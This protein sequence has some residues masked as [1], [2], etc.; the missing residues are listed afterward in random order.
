[1]STEAPQPTTTPTAPPSNAPSPSAAAPTGTP[2]AAIPS[3]PF[4][5]G[6]NA[7]TWA[8]GKTAEEVLGIAEKLTGVVQTYVQTNAPLPTQPAPTYNVPTPTAP[9]FDP[10]SYIQRRDMETLAPRMIQD[11]VAPQFKSLYENLA[12]SNLETVKRSNAVIFEKY[13][14]EV[15]S[16][17]AKVPIEQ[18]TV[19]N[20]TTIVKLVR[21][22]HVDE[23]ASEIASRRVAEMEPTLRSN[24]SPAVP[25][26]TQE[27]KYTLQSDAIPQDWKDRAATAGLTEQAVEEFCRANDMTKAQFYSQF[28][29][30]AITEVTQRG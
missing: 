21:A 9:T 24:G 27:Q 19:D 16:Y 28:G 4:R 25:V 23:L 15:Y 14:P 5:Y 12:Q 2:S 13:G 29:K 26:A 17:L 6:A 30:T 11:T 10:D 18:R 20:L 22:D 7:P 1:M 8:Q 3:E